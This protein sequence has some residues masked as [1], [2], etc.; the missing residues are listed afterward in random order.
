VNEQY[1]KVLQNNMILDRQET[2]FKIDK[3]SEV[4]NKQNES[5]NEFEVSNNLNESTI[6]L[7]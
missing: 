7:Y 4:S 1:N 2:S 6:F 3:A 5:T